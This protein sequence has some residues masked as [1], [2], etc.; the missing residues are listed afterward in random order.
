MIRSAGASTTFVLGENVSLWSTIFPFL[1]TIRIIKNLARKT[2][3]D[4]GC[5]TFTYLW[6]LFRSTRAAAM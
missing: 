1:T 6:H 4:T 2:I 3:L 5:L